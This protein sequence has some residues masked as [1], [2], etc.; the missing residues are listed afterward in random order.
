MLSH[1]FHPSILRAYDIRGTF[2]QTLFETDATLLGYKLATYLQ[3]TRQKKSYTLGIVRDGRQSSPLLH[4]ALSKAL[5]QTGIHSVDFGTGPSPMGYFATFHTPIDGVVIV[6]ASH[7]PKEDNG[8]KILL[9]GKNICGSELQDFAKLPSATPTP[10]DQRGTYTQK[11]ILKAYATH[12]LKALKQIEPLAKTHKIKIAWDF[13]HGAMSVIRPFIEAA[14]PAY[15]YF[16]CDTLD[17]GFPSH[18]PDPTVPKNLAMLQE[19]VTQKGCDIGFAFDGDGDRLGVVDHNGDIIHGDRLVAILAQ[20]VLKHHQGATILADMK[21]SR[22]FQ[23]TIT[24]HGGIPL[25][26]RTGHS[27]IKEKMKETGALLAGEMSGH[28][29]FAD[30]N[31]GYDDGFYAACRVLRLLNRT[32]KSME[33]LNA[34]LPT[35]AST[36]EIKIPLQEHLRCQVI[37]DV[38]HYLQASAISFLDEDG[39]RAETKDGWWLIRSSHTEDFLILRFEGY[40]P[41][42]L[43]VIQHQCLT[44]LEKVSL[45]T[46]KLAT[47]MI[48]FL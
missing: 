40:N 21:S 35:Y 6:T 1:A 48:P 33:A 9:F 23:Q 34:N 17:G 4:K 11:N 26:T 18:D 10:P 42:A 2:G 27:F 13:S 41:K 44:I 7:N 32:G 20:D 29:F 45:E 37:Q 12:T 16:L 31:E 39:V 43:E 8:F 25:L 19:C 28:I 46:R 24:K 22:V 3:Q 36:P 15:H 30:E 14:L 47:K 5:C 38:R